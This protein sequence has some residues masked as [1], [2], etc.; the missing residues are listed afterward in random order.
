MPKL[1]FLLRKK[2]LPTR[3]KFLFTIMLP[4]GRISKFFGFDGSLS[5]NLYDTFP[6]NFNTGEP[7]YVIIDMLAVPLFLEHF[8]KRGRNGAIMRFAD[9]DNQIRAEEFIGCEFFITADSD[10]AKTLTPDGEEEELYFENLVG[11]NAVIAAG[12]D[13]N[14]PVRG[15]ITSYIDNEMNPL[16]CMEAAG[17]DIYIP[18]AD[19]FISSVDTGAETIEFELPEGLLGL[20]L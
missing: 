5:V 8:E 14:E 2:N 3:N 18:A 17:K 1:K 13:N 11:Y 12:P 19:E 16:L 6:D 9:I 10:G 20:Y 7:L 15:R 4:A